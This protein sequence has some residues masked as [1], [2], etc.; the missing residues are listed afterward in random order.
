MNRTAGLLLVVLS[1]LF[2]TSLSAYEPGDFAPRGSLLYTRVEDLAGAAKKLF[3]EDWRVQA[4]RMLLMRDERDVRESDP[5]L[6]EL[7]G[8]VDFLGTTEFIIGDV[9]IRE[10]Y[11]QSATVVQLKEGAPAKFSEAFLEWIKDNDRDAEIKEDSIGFEGVRIWLKSSLLVITTGGMMDVHVQDVIDGFNDE[12]LSKVERFTKWSS[13]AKGDVVLFADMKAWRTAVDRLGEDFS[14]DLR[15]ALDVVEWQKWDMVAGTISLPGR[16]GGGIAADLS[17]SLNQPFEKLNAFLK[18]SGGSRLVG[19]LP[20]ECVG[21]LSLQLGRD[22]QR[23]YSDLLGYFHDFEQDDRPHRLRRQRGWYE[24]DLEWAEQRLKNLEELKANEKGE[25]DEDGVADPGPQGVKAQPVPVPEEEEGEEYVEPTLDEQIAEARE[26]VD[27]YKQ[28]I[29]ELNEQIN[30]HEYRAFEPDREVRNM[31]GTDAED[32]HDELLEIF[33]Q[34]GLTLDETLNSVGHEALLGILNLPDPT[35]DDN[36]LDNAYEDMW[37]TLVETAESWPEFKEKLLDAVLGRQLPEDTPEELREEAKE[38][39]EALMFKKVDG[40]EILRLRG[41]QADFCFF[42]GEGFVGVGANEDVALRIL[43]SA[44][45]QGRMSTSNIPGGTVGGSKFS[46]VNLGAVLTKISRG[47][48]NRDR[49]RTRMPM[50]FFDL[51]KYLPAGFH[52]SL[53]SDESSHALRFTFRT[54]GESDGSNV[55]RM[56]ADEMHR[57]LGYDHDRRMLEDLQHSIGL[58]RDAN[59]AGLQEMGDAERARTLKGVTPTSLTDDGHFTPM[60]GMR[61]AFDPAMAA[62]LKAMLESYTEVLGPAEGENNPADFG[63]SG[64]EWRGLPD[65]YG[66]GKHASLHIVCMMRGD[67]AHNGRLAIVASGSDLDLV[68]LHA[69]EFVRLQ[70]AVTSGQEYK[71]EVAPGVKPPKWRVRKNLARKVYQIH[72]LRGKVM[73]LKRA[74]EEAGVEFKLNFKGGEEEDPLGALRELLGISEDDW[75]HFENP[76]ALTIETDA[77]GKVSAKLEM[78]EHWVEVDEDGNVTSSFDE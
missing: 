27:E 23:T 73:A 42:A 9:M 70:E 37:F 47:N 59:A 28:R 52:M 66:T 12:S 45:G 6:N 19:V 32:F 22:H 67:W 31:R 25:K 44:M 13:K 68:W 18:P 29:A 8:F 16:T 43:K 57:Q 3:G 56:F 11:V 4:E 46:Y 61:S 33:E 75:F 55:M 20:S 64:F 36:D 63:E 60:D 26:R 51:E 69:E 50:P 39:A 40:G 35:F 77:E 76:E 2:A 1:G 62:R 21:F 65:D 14:D 10:P 5:V 72:N 38:R 24:S 78:D 58:W 53:A 41:L 17:L 49:L 15:R 48:Y 74:A 30:S 34:L 7:R 71:P 54:A